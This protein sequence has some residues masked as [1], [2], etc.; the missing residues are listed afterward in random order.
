MLAPERTKSRGVPMTHLCLLWN[1]LQ[2]LQN[3]ASLSSASYTYDSDI[4][5]DVTTGLNENLCQLRA[6]EFCACGLNRVVYNNSNL[7]LNFSELEHDYLTLFLR[8]SSQVSSMSTACQ[9][10]VKSMSKACH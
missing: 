5:H 8:A 1:V 10:H 9:Q 6:I 4:F 2:D 7:L 3:A